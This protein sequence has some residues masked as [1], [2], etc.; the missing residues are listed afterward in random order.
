MRKSFT[1]EERLQAVIQAIAS[2]DEES[3][4]S[5]AVRLAFH[6]HYRRELAFRLMRYLEANP[7]TAAY[8]RLEPASRMLDWNKIRSLADK[9]YKAKL[10]SGELFPQPTLTGVALYSREVLGPRFH[11]NAIEMGKRILACIRGT[12]VDEGAQ[13]PKAIGKETALLLCHS[14]AVHPG[15]GEQLA[16]CL[17]D[18]LFSV[19]KYWPLYEERRRED[20]GLFAATLA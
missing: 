2:L 11:R 17:P 20:L 19:K 5:R 9:A 8:T 10:R 7:T 14:S 4:R 1:V 6:T 13:L 12:G 15:V 16:K 18:S 3:Y